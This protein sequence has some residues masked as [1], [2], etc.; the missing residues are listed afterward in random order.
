MKD[1]VTFLVALKTYG[2]H[3]L[4]MVFVCLWAGRAEN[5]GRRRGDGR[6]WEEGGGGREGGEG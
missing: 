3:T 4:V 1:V 5:R 2:W 6:G